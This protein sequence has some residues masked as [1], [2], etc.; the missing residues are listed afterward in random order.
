MKLLIAVS[1]LLIAS[2]GTAFDTRMVLGKLGSEVAL[3]MVWGVLLLV[4]GRSIR[5]RISPPAMI[6]RAEVSPHL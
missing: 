6:A 5:V 2:G 1:L 4:A 3:L